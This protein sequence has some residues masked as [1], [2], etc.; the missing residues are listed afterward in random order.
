MVRFSGASA[1]TPKNC[2]FPALWDLASV[3]VELSRP[4]PFVG[5]VL[6]LQTPDQNSF[7]SSLAPR[8]SGAPSSEMMVDSSV[9]TWNGLPESRRLCESVFFPPA[10]YCP[11]LHSSD[12]NLQGQ[13]VKNSS[14]GKK[15]VKL[16]VFPTR[17][18]FLLSIKKT[19]PRRWLALPLKNFAGVQSN[20]LSGLPRGTGQIGP[21]VK[22]KRKGFVGFS[23]R[24]NQLTSGQPERLEQTS[25][26][27]RP[28]N[29][30]SI[31]AQS[32][33]RAKKQPGAGSVAPFQGSGGGF[34]GLPRALP[35]ADLLGPFGAKSGQ[36]A[37]SCSLALKRNS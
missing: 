32:P 18:T 33:E 19:S 20:S 9:V 1:P 14:T 8:S 17:R 23:F 11:F 28:G 2:S 24:R 12:P 30:G 7:S 36:P 3:G 6:S 37:T 27:Q 26:G 34:S 31:G 15:V 10:L 16:K 21:L 13:Q 35:W 29:P 4:G 22:G 25:P 5:H